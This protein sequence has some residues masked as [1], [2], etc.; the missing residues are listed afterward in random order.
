M[1]GTS[2]AILIGLIVAV[3]MYANTLDR[4]A[5]GYMFLSLLISPLLTFILLVIIGKKRY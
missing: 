2:A 5:L 3:G 1:D 4:N